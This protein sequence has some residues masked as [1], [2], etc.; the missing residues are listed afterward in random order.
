MLNENRLYDAQNLVDTIC[1]TN[2]KVKINHKSDELIE[3]VENEKIILAEDNR[4]LLF[5]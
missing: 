1:G 2:R 5:S 3:R 4:Q